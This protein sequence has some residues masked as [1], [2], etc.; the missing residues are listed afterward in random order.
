MFRFEMESVGGHPRRG[1]LVAGVAAY[2]PTGIV[3]SGDDQTQAVTGL[4]G[5]GNGNGLDGGRVD[6]ARCQKLVALERVAK[7]EADYAVAQQHGSTIGMNVCESESDI[8]VLRVRRQMESKRDVSGDLEIV[9]EGGGGKDER[10]AMGF[11]LFSLVPR[12]L[13]GYL[14]LVLAADRGN[15]VVGIAGEGDVGGTEGWGLRRESVIRVQ[16]ERDLA[17]VFRRPMLG[18]LPTVHAHLVV[19]DRRDLVLPV[20]GSP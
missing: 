14:C 3:A 2:V 5:V 6:L 1:A 20:I 16:E 7:A 18:G 15:R 11:D 9:L 8:G 12:P 10:I 4:E 17:H 13:P 19:D